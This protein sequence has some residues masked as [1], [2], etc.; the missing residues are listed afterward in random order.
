MKLALN[1]KVDKVPNSKKKCKLPVYRI[2]DVLINFFEATFLTKY[3]VMHEIAKL[4]PT[5]F[6]RRWRSDRK[7]PLEVGT[8]EFTVALLQHIITLKGYIQSN[9][10]IIFDEKQEI[11]LNLD[12]PLL[13]SDEGNKVKQEY[14]IVQGSCLKCFG[15]REIT[16]I[17][18]DERDNNVFEITDTCTECDGLGL[19]TRFIP[20]IPKRFVGG[21]REKSDFFKLSNIQ[22]YY[23]RGYKIFLINFLSSRIHR[24]I[25]GLYDEETNDIIEPT[26]LIVNARDYVSTSDELP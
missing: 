19:I 7:T 26:T 22:Q 25:F 9:N 12:G 3:Q 20:S 11:Y 18:H 2:P 13:S 1:P 8:N 14:D 16:H 24:Y 4:S 21:I 17:I 23:S 10:V 15:I 6:I 5:E